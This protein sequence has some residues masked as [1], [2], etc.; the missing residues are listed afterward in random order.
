[1]KWKCTQKFFRQ[2]HKH[3]QNY[4]V[5]RTSL[6]LTFWTLSVWTSQFSKKLG[7]IQSPLSVNKNECWAGRVS[8]ISAAVFHRVFHLF[9][10][11][12]EFTQGNKEISTADTPQYRKKNN[13]GLMCLILN[14]GK[15]HFDH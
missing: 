2:K 1:M 9:R 13:E 6:L 3:K 10:C 11:V 8:F 7:I 14:Q 12:A 4:L 15:G 5:C